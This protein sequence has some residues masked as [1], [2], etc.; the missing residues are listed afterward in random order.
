MEAL[1]AWE[2]RVRPQRPAARVPVYDG[3]DGRE[4]S[5]VAIQRPCSQAEGL[6]LTTVIG[7]H[8]LL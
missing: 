6:H 5:R 3:K 1:G 8:G 2:G 4:G 7:S